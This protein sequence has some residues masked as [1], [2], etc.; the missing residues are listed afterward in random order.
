MAVVLA[1]MAFLIVSLVWVL[2]VLDWTN[3]YLVLT[4]RRIIHFERFG[5]LRE[6]RKEIP[7]RAV[8]NVELSS[9][10]PTSILG[11]AD[12]TVKTI[13]GVL[14]FTH[15]A[16]AEHLQSRILDQRALDQQAVRREDR[17]DIRQSL[18]KVLKPESLR[19][20]P[21]PP[22][23]AGGTAQA[24]RVAQP[25]MESGLHFAPDARER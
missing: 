14:T 13:G 3:D 2:Y 1:F 11:L 17:E 22:L 19:V 10:W 9:G 8:Q 21:L 12:I 16:D 20:S 4:N 24:C 7:I 25:P 6:T 18:I 15:I 5:I 23:D